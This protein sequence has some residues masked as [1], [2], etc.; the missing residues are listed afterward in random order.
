MLLRGLLLMLLLLSYSDLKSDREEPFQSI[1]KVNL[2]TEH[3]VQSPNFAVHNGFAFFVTEDRLHL[4]KVDLETGSTIRSV[5]G[6]GNG[7]GEFDKKIVNI[8]LLDG[9]IWVFTSN[10]IHYFDLSL[11]FMH[12]EVI[13]YTSRDVVRLITGDYLM[14]TMSLAEIP[15]QR[16]AYNLSVAKPGMLEN[17][18]HTRFRLGGSIQNFNLSECHIDA[19]KLLVAVAQT[20]GTSV[21][22][23]NMAGVL[24][25]KVNIQIATGEISFLPVE[26]PSMITSM[27]AQL[28][29]TDFRVPAGGHVS[30]IH[31]TNE[32]TI[33]QGFTTS[34]N[35]TTSIAVIEHGTWRVR[36]Q[37]LPSVCGTMRIADDKMFCLVATDDESYIEE[38]DLALEDLFDN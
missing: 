22:F 38:F 10:T 13:K 17:A 26:Q 12:R 8:R 11:N 34:A 6:E 15:E 31:T 16:S 27:Y 30:N 5:G 32:Y 36:K 29:Y 19:N 20:G 4:L 7:P 24:R 3:S 25:K 9:R 35:Y 28:G 33:V 18:N 2:T 37:V 14:C 23:Y 21:R 1:R